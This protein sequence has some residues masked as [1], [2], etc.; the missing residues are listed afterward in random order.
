M[1]E[2]LDVARIRVNENVCACSCG[3]K[4]WRRG[5]DLNPRPLCGDRLSR[6]APWTARA[7]RRPWWPASLASGPSVGGRVVETL[8]G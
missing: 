6:P 5:R 4:H 8:G 3:V 2:I 1:H 7:P